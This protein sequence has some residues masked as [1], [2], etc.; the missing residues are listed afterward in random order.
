MS[1]TSLFSVQGVAN[2]LSQFV[3]S[4]GGRSETVVG[5]SVGT[6]SIK[7]VELKR[8]RGSWQLL[9]FGVIQLAEDIIINREIINSIAATES[10]KAL[11]AQIKLGGDVVC[12]ALAGTSMIIKRMAVEAPKLKDLASQTYWEAEQYLPFDVS[13]VVMD[14]HVLSRTREGST[15]LVL[16]AVKKNDLEAYSRCIQDAGLKPQIMDVDFFA[17]QNIFEENYPGSLKEAVALVDLGASSMKIIIMQNQIPLFTK[18]SSIGGRNLTHDIQQSLNLSY[19]DAESLKIGDQDGRSMPQE[20]NELMAV[21]V[22]NL[23]L[24]I[25][26]SLDF[27]QASSSGDAVSHVLLTGGCSKIRGLAKAIESF[28]NVPTQLLNPFNAISYDPQVFTEDYISNIGPLASI[29]LG[30]AL[31]MGSP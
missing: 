12:A 3:G 26:R 7:L 25:K 17:L 29:P 9:H 8:L 15:D 21:M 19:V 20:L 6:S 14:Y 28:L 4:L 30:L 22:E 31:R 24:E 1:E 10:I 13:E 18:D 27:Y 23:A 2:F 5:L 11:L 16:V